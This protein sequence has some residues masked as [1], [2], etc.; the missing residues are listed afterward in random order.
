M[1]DFFN[2]FLSSR[3]IL[4]LKNH[5]F[6]KNRG[7]QNGNMLGLL[8]QDAYNMGEFG[9]CGTGASSRYKK[10]DPSRLYINGI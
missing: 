1:K 9:G 5:G 3:N 6:V 8:S 10:H 2:D 4:F 7:P